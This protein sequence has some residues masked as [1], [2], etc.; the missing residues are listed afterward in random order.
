MS[1]MDPGFAAATRK[2][3]SGPLVID[4]C[5]DGDDAYGC[6]VSDGCLVGPVR[7]SHCVSKGCRVLSSAC[8][9][10]DDG[11]W[12]AADGS[13]IFSSDWNRCEATF[14]NTNSSL[15]ARRPMAKKR[16]YDDLLD[17]NAADLMEK[18][19]V[20]PMGEVQ[21]HK[22]GRGR[23]RKKPKMARF[24][25]V[26]GANFTATSN[27]I[28]FEVA[29]KPS[30]K[31]RAAFGRNCNRYNPSKVEE[32]QF[33]DVLSSLCCQNGGSVPK[34]S[35]NTL[36]MVRIL[37]FFPRTNASSTLFGQADINN[38]C[39]FVLDALNKVL[40]ADDRQIVELSASK[41][42]DA[43]GSIGRTTVSLTRQL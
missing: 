42:F 25:E 31:K 3:E 37:F 2:Y 29:G 4:L 34:F 38:L 20:L 30:S 28:Y 19:S 1:K 12:V 11:N 36:L 10:D 40:Y 41:C 18:D 24:S 6:R 26:V 35:A 32:Q 27:K 22:R 43:A 23:P 16:A 13:T 17:L 14:P 21:Q 33:V 39:K 5:D 7:E 15:C 9:G 8:A